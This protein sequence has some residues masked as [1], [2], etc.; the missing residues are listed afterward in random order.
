M[1]TRHLASFLVLPLA[2]AA[3]TDANQSAV[4]EGETAVQGVDCS[5]LPDVEPAKAVDP[6]SEHDVPDTGTATA[7]LEMAAGDVTL[8]LDRAK[9]PCAVQSFLSLAE[10]GYFDD[11]RCHRLVDYGIF[12]LQCGDPTAT[13]TGG[14]GYV[15][16]DEVT[17]DLV[18]SS[19]VV[20]MANRG[21]DTNGSQFF[22]VFDET[23][24]PPDYTI[25]GQMDEA[26]LQVVRD[27]AAQSVDPVDGITPVADASI[28]AVVVG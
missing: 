7:T 9:A 10:Q 12:I 15:F 18:Y 4:S 14:P 25:F 23:E 20:A 22:L 16:A 11:T 1:R 26:G 28:N 24:L 5:Y 2:I 6:P 17:D 19:G 27:I 8:T 3:C 13:G 21:P